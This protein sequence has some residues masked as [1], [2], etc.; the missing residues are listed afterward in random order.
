[1][2]VPRLLEAGYEV[3]GVDNLF[4]HNQHALAGFLGHHNFEF[5]K[6]D[7]CNLP[8]DIIN[9]HDIVIHLA[10]IVGAPACDKFSTISE[11]V[12]VRCVERLCN[13]AD[14]KIRFIGVCTNSG[15]G[16]KGEQI[17]S[18]DAPMEPLSAYGVQKCKA[19]KLILERGN[20]VSL[21]L[22]TVFGVSP[23]MRFDLLLNDFVSKFVFDGKLEL[24]EPYFIR[25][26]VH[27][28][29]V[30]RSIVWMLDTRFE[31]P[32]N[33]ALPEANLT[34]WAVADL[35]RRQMNLPSSALTIGNGTDPDK[36]NCAVSTLKLTNS[37][38]KYKYRLWDG[39]YEV[40]KYCEMLTKEQVKKMGNV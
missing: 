5:F 33:V 32:Y 15:Y 37:G 39:I 34:K 9:E 35:I 7:I 21:R 1:M 6:T 3:S 23:R 26:A 14:K 36:R 40:R 16:A 10:A 19:E 25:N 24:Y 28:R 2:L 11:S 13:I 17:C 30:C 12:N 22:A 38:F 29:D 20:S 31:G 27:I 4:Y 8:K 18:E